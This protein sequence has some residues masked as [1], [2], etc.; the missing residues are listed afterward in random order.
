[1]ELL[2]AF[3]RDGSSQCPSA[4]DALWVIRCRWIRVGWPGFLLKACIKIS[5]YLVNKVCSFDAPSFWKILHSD[6]SLFSKNLI[7]N[8][9]SIF[10]YIGSSTEHELIT[11]DSYCK[12]IHKESM[13]F[14][15]HDLRCHVS[16]C[17]TGVLTVLLS[18]LS[19]YSH[20]SYSEIPVLIKH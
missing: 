5:K 4:K 8:L 7:A 6:T 13:I 19:R 1:M 16:R 10:T 17:S 14:S 20:V 11:H 9:F 15:D 2:S 12:E 18:E 3:F